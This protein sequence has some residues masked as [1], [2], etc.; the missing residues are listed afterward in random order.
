MRFKPGSKVHVP[1]DEILYLTTIGYEEDADRYECRTR[2]DALIFVQA[3]LGRSAGR[4]HMT[5]PARVLYGNPRIYLLAMDTSLGWHACDDHALNVCAK[6]L[7]P[8]HLWPPDGICTEFLTAIP[9]HTSPTHDI[10]PS[11]GRLF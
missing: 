10:P 3:G 7:Q 11:P 5:A 9:A 6:C 8:E 1:G 2:W 4:S